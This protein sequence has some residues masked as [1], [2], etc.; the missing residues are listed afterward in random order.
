VLKTTSPVGLR[1]KSVA[2]VALGSFDGLHVGHQAILQRAVEIARHSG[3]LSAVF[4]FHPHPGSVT[5]R[6]GMR[7]ITTPKQRSLLIEKHGIDVLIEQ[8]FTSTFA[9]LSPQQFVLDVLLAAFGATSFVAGFNYSFGHRAEGDMNMLKRLGAQHQFAV[10]EVEPIALAGE[11][12]SST[13]VRRLLEQGDL[14][15][16]ARCLGRPF[17]LQGE[18]AV[19]DGRGRKLGFPTANVSLAKEQ[20]LPPRGVYLVYAPT[21]GFGVAN[22]GVRPTFPL[23]DAA[24][25]VHFLE[26]QGLDLYGRELE[27]ELLLYL[28]PERVFTD[29]VA[30]QEQVEQDIARARALAYSITKC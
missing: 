26:S 28:R 10:H 30:L 1:D 9:S 24:L 23:L 7:T 27:V 6:N 14:E 13:R 22:L 3:A 20:V 18:V 5:G 11:T 8:P 29:A 25:E 17:S 2:A 19:G 16:A 4:T 15:S 21:F 12:V